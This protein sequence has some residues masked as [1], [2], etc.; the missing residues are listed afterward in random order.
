MPERIKIEPISGFPEWLPNVRLL[1]EHFLAVIREQYRLYGFTPIE[2]P[3]VERWDVLTAKGGVQRQIFS[4]GK[5]QEGDTEAELGLH[6]DLTVPL[7]R[8]VVQHSGQIVFPFRRYQIQKVW[9]GERAQAGRF[10]E[11][12]QA[13]VDVIGRGSL[14]LI[15]DAEMPCVINSTF[16]AL[17][18]PD[19]Q[20]QISNRKILGD[21][22]RAHDLNEEEGKKTLRAIDKT[23]DADIATM[24]AML[25]EEGV[26]AQLVPAVVDLLQCQQISDARGVLDTIGAPSSGL[27]ELQM[28]YDNALILGTPESR[29]RVNFA[30]ARGLDY[31]TGT[32]YETMLL[33]NEDLGSV[34]SG[35]RFDDLASYFSPQKFPGVGIS[36]GLS[37]LIAGLL[38]AELIETH[39]STPTDVLVTMQDRERYLNEYL[40]MARTL[41]DRGI[42]TELALEPGGLRD[43]IGYA[44]SNGI[45]L[46]LIAGESEI[47]EKVVTVRDMRSRDQQLV[48]RGQ[49]VDYVLEKLRP[50]SST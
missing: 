15:H 28:V 45:P 13:D 41:R 10:K 26:D 25:E 47:E 14:D 6:F 48:A 19:F 27:D 31:Y 16:E 22:I 33:G 3:A 46:T 36:I 39:R 7:A 8:Y 29:L 12:Y 42:R 40:S 34:C 44:A 38:K 11:F 21:L 20:V 9:R 1:E 30:I 2:T 23:S 49:L 32:V 24:R 37:R 4:V 43:Q 35:G 50:A 5:P 17:E 18:L